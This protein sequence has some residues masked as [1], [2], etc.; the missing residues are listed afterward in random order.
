MHDVVC[1]PMWTAYSTCYVI[2]GH[3]S[4]ITNDLFHTLH[5]GFSWH[6]RKT[7]RTLPNSDVLPSLVKLS[8]PIEHSFPWET[9]VTIH[10]M[11]FT[12][13]FFCGQSFG[14]QKMHNCMLFRSC[15]L[16]EHTLPSWSGFHWLIVYLSDR[17]QPLRQAYIC[18]H[19]LTKWY[20]GNWHLR[21]TYWLALVIL[22]LGKEYV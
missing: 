20:E 5:C 1:G 17:T 8:D 16:M 21:L 9:V 2:N 7:I 6:L 12:M 19:L 13:H 22:H 15:T 10:G 18:C 3:T 4:V 11:H 14:L